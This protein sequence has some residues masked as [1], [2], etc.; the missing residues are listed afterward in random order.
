MPPSRQARA[1]QQRQKERLA[2]AQARRQERRQRRQRIGVTLG[3]LVLIIALVIAFAGGMTN[4]DT[5]KAA[6]PTTLAT[7]PTTASTRVVKQCVG[8]KD[9]LPKGAPA[10]PITAGPPPKKLV[11]KDLKVGTGAV[12]K[13]TDNVNVDYVGV[14]CSTGKVFDSSYSNGKPVDFPLNGVIQ[15]WTQGIPGMRVG[16]VRLLSIP[17]DLAYGAA[18]NGPVGPNEPLFFLVAVHKIDA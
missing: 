6:T 11:T 1:R 16:G 12:V 2:I 15:G 18:G 9:A 10:M 5:K 17:P 14:A 8:L 7:T 3:A 13:A 4:S